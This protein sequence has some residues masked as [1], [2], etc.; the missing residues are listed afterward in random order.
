MIKV[1]QVHNLTTVSHSYGFYMGLLSIV[2]E[3]VWSQNDNLKGVIPM[4]GGM[5]LLMSIFAGIGFLYGEAGLRQLLSDSGVYAS[6]TAT[7]IL[8]G[9]DFDRGLMA[10][11]LID[12]A[13]HNRLLKNFIAWC[14]RNNTAIHCDVTEMLSKFRSM[15][16]NK[17]TDSSIKQFCEVISTHIF[18]LLDEFREEF[19]KISPP[20]LVWMNIS[21]R[22]QCPSN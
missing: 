20:F 17:Y 8:T 13:L 7:N 16:E 19:R 14:E 10:F 18:Q 4:E 15:N 9:K 22:Y 1:A 11:K 2:L 5:H 21:Q 12:E 3:I 6:V